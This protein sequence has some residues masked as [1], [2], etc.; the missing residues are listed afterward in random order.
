M[1]LMNTFVICDLHQI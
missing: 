1:G